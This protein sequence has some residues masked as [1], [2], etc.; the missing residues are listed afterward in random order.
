M[1]PPT[2]PKDHANF[3]VLKIKLSP[4]KVVE[5]INCGYNLFT[6][7]DSVEKMY[8]RESPTGQAEVLGIRQLNPAEEVLAF[9]CFPV[10]YEP[11]RTIAQQTMQVYREG[12]K[13]IAYEV[14]LK[15]DTAV[16]PCTFEK[17]C[18]AM[19]RMIAIDNEYQRLYEIDGQIVWD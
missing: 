12:H 18:G 11:T 10:E 14:F 3:Y 19:E 5:S 8:H 2:L 15:D 13:E 7:S 16:L 6:V 4:R 1:T 9:H 17:F